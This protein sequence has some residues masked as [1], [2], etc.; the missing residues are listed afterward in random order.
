M[1]LQR[2]RRVILEDARQPSGVKLRR[3]VVARAQITLDPAA[4]AAAQTDQPLPVRGQLIP[5]EA[6]RCQRLALRV[7]WISEESRHSER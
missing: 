2:Q 3:G 5:A 6:T 4:P 7:P 1:Q